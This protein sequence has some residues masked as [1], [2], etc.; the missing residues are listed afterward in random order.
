MASTVSY[1]T[2]CNFVYFRVQYAKE[3]YYVRFKKISKPA[4]FNVLCERSYKFV[5]FYPITLEYTMVVKL[6]LRHLM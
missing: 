4:V 3:Y 2:N 5:C 6:A 1:T